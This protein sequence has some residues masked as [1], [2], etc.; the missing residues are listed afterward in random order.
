M[1]FV[2]LS[3]GIL[4]VVILH[5]T[6]KFFA[7]AQPSTIRKTIKW[8]A[9]AA[10]VAIIFFL[11]RFGLLHMAAIVSFLSVVVPLLQR[12]KAV[13]SR[14]NT[15]A[16]NTSRMS[17]EEALE[18]LGLHSGQTSRT[19]IQAAHRRMIQKNHPDQGGSKYLASKIN[20]ARDVLL[21]E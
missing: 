12:F 20:E 21:D 5:T 9:I 16:S 10:V 11:I 7:K 17:R 15:P 19:E 13:K 1:V 18:I 3:L 14:N 6:L 4:L 8:L 2:Y